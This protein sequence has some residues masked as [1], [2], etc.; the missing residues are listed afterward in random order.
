MC[1]RVCACVYVCM[2]GLIRSTETGEPQPLCFGFKFVYFLCRMNLELFRA[3]D[4]MNAPVVT[5]QQVQTRPGPGFSPGSSSQGSATGF[6]FRGPTSRVQL[7]GPAPGKRFSSLLH[8]FSNL[9]NLWIETV[10]LILVLSK[11]GAGRS[12]KWFLSP[13]DSTKG[14]TTGYLT[15][16]T[17]MSLE[18]QASHGTQICFP[19]ASTRWSL[20][21]TWRACSL[22]RNTAGSRW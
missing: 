22:R 17:N 15:T 4:V 1:V 18:P 21:G 6:S 13:K 5:I 20:S 10:D 16:H 11:Q 8:R 12:A 9:S 7:Q 3:A 14:T 19:S 2:R